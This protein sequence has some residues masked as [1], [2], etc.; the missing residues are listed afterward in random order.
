M[1][2]KAHDVLNTFLHVRDGGRS[3]IVPV[4]ETFWQDLSGGALPHLEEGRLMTAFT[5]AEP[6][7][8]W[9]RHL[10]GEELVLLLSGVVD[11]VLES[12]AGE[13]VVR[14]VRPGEFVL[15]PAGVWHTARTATQ[16][17]MLFLTPGRGT[18]HRPCA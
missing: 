18:E 17:T 10:A 5:F 13:Q 14:L 4:S 16:T 12:P 7:A 6:W 15:V 2:E 1:G 3:N 9:E 8:T 11:M